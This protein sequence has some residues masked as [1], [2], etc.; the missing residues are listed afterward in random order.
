MSISRKKLPVKMRDVNKFLSEMKSTSSPDL[1][2]RWSK[3]EEFYNKKLWHQ[4]T[5]QLQE[6]VKE[7]SMQDKLISVYQDFI[8]EFEAK[9]DPLSLAMISM[10]ILDRFT[11]AEEAIIFVEKIGEKIKMNKEAF[12]LTRVLVGKIKLHQFEQQKET[13]VRFTL[14]YEF[15]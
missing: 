9:L 11:S 3:V 10:V 8:V 2:A 1:S 6:I 15:F 4:L 5:C 14:P 12:A 7:P 13:K